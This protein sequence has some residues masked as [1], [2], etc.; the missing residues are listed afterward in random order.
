MASLTTRRCGGPLVAEMLP[1]HRW[2]ECDVC[3]MPK[4]RPRI[5][6]KQ[7]TDRKVK[8][9][10]TPK[11]VGR[12]GGPVENP[13]GIAGWDDHGFVPQRKVEGAQ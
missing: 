6:P 13:T 1:S 3:T 5:P 8:C 12:M 4:L 11:C 9:S 10:M 2:Y 7:V